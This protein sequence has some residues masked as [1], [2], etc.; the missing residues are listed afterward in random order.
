VKQLSSQR[1]FEGELVYCE[2]RAQSTGCDMRF[3]V[4][5]PPGVSAG[6]P[7]PVVW[8]LSGLTCTADN[9][10]GKAGAYR[11]AAEQGLIIVAPD[12]SPRGADVPDDEAYDLGQGAGFYLDATEAPW[13]TNFRMHSYITDEL[14]RLVMA[15]FPARQ[16]AQGIA[17]HSMGGHGALTLGLRHP[18]LYRSISAFAPIVAPARVPWGRKAFSAYLGDD[19]SSWQGHDA[20]ALMTAAGDRSG[21]APILID[22]G[23]ADEFLDEQLKPELFAAACAE[24]GQVL[25]LRH[26]A[27]YDHSYFFIATFIDDHIAHHARLLNAA[28]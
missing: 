16:D 17:G 14:Q 15:E 11:A 4:F 21:C 28:G 5:L 23:Q 24:S 6:A 20:T 25:E 2:H 19:E 18:D 1:V 26:H 13:Q 27:G 10:T 3:S 12:T 7:A 9:F 22:Q 8:W